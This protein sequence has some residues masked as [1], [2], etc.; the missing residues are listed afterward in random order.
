[1]S[2]RTEL[3]RLARA[4]TGGLISVEEAAVVL[5]RSRPATARRLAELTRQGWLARV[6]R[7]LY[8]VMPLDAAP[9]RAPEMVEDA[10]V[11]ASRVF[12][13]C[14]IGGWSAAEHWGLT[15]QIFRTTLVVSAAEVRETEQELGGH[16]YRVF[17][18]PRAALGAGVRLVWRGAERVP[19][20]G[21]ERTI[22]DC[23]R[24]PELCGGVRHLAEI[25]SA[26]ASDGNAD[27]DELLRV[28]R[29]RANGAAWKRLGYLAEQLWPPEVAAAVIA[30]ARRR[31]SS[32]YVKLD[33]AARDQGRRSARWGLRLNVPIQADSV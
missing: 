21:P 25:M 30:A 5:A 20:S 8:Q 2:R 18:I 24:N 14:Y 28:A 33:P 29:A 12:A 32:G 27:V 11:L 23:L 4:A 26:Y 22:V 7:G 17:R 13:P 16:R 6:R 15:E 9:S 19:V 10:W 31:L 1:M 3:A